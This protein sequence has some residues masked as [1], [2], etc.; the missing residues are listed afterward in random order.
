MNI[1][2][3]FDKSFEYAGVLQTATIAFSYAYVWCFA[4]YDDAYRVYSFA[5]LMAFEF[6]MVHSGV[7]MAIFPRKVS[8]WL[9]F[10]LYG[11]FA[12][13]FNA[14]LQVGDNSILIIYLTTVLTRM[15]FAFFDA[16]KLIKQRMILMSIVA[17]VIYFV[18][19]MVSVFMR[20]VIPPLALGEDFVQSEAYQWIKSGEGLFVEA[21]YVPIFAGFIYYTLISVVDYRLTRNKQ[22]IQRY[23][24]TSEKEKTV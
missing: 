3:R 18:V 13:S 9:F 14:S 15:R 1:L 4:T 22:L 23:F 12:W 19:L 17:A 10:P 5:T 16:N 21:P 8:L 7:F 11:L 24:H 6:I 20:N 2:E